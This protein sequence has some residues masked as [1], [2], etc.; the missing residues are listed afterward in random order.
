VRALTAASS[1]NSWSL[2]RD[3]LG[4]DVPEATAVVRRSLEALLGV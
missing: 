1:W 3:D 4:L 2:L